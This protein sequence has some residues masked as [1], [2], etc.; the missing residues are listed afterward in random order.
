[1]IG[2]QV[3]LKARHATLFYGLTALMSIDLLNI[4]FRK[5]HPKLLH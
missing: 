2:V 5:L 4:G 3:G 1:M